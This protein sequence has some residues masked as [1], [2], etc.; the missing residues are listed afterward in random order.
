MAVTVDLDISPEQIFGHT[1]KLPEHAVKAIGE[2]ALRGFS[3]KCVERGVLCAPEIDGG[4]K[5]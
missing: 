5:L 3:Q 1:K 2:P 4:M